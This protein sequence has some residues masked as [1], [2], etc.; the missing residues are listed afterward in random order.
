MTASEKA[1]QIGLRNRFRRLTPVLMVCLFAAIA[2]E[3]SMRPNAED[4]E[5]FH[6]SIR[7]L[8]SQLPVRIGHW[9]GKSLAVSNESVRLLNPN[10]IHR[11][12]FVHGQ[13]GQVVHVLLVHC[14]DARDIYGHYP[15]RCYPSQGK[16]QL[17]AVAK[18]W[19]VAGH[20]VPG[21]EYEFRTD[22]PNLIVDNFI[23]V[24]ATETDTNGRIERDMGTVKKRAW[25]YRNRHYGAAQF[26]VV[27]RDPRLSTEDR[28]RI[29]TELV[30]AYM[31]VI[32]AIR[33]G[34]VLKKG[35]QNG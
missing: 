17:S 31:P 30:E 27:Y 8:S 22:G 14:K 10:V 13:T 6:Q 11:R 2:V 24:P 5:P 12:R 21:I 28:T 20:S 1:R 3:S 19:L 9:T 26:Q 29:F 23:I 18:D 25:E 35:E 7:D 34:S 32:E 15:P 33:K 16:S 4:S